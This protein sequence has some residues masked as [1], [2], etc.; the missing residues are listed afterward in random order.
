MNRKKMTDILKMSVV[1][2]YF[3][4]ILSAAY[5]C[6]SRLSIVTGGTPPA[7]LRSRSVSAPTV[8][9][10]FNG[11]CRRK[12][13]GDTERCRSATGAPVER[14]RSEGGGAE[15]CKKMF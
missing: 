4:P 5:L 3:R 8:L 2:Y 9:R 14:L 12:V 15:E 6:P 13:G 10:L 11:F 1:F 7:P